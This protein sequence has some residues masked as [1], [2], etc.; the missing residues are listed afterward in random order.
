M[1]SMNDV[2]RRAGVSIA[3]VS[4]VLNNSSSVNEETRLKILKAIKELKY[5]PSRVAKRLRSKGG[6]GNLLGVLIPDIQNPFYVD[7]LRGIEDI[8]YKNNYV[9]I[10]CNFSQDEKKEAMY[11]DILES[12]AIDGLIA[13]PASE[14]DV[15][16]KKMVQNGLPVVCVDR[17]LNGIDV[18]VVWVN[19]DAGAF[20]AVDYLAKAGYKRIGHIAGLPTIPSSRL[21]EA[22]YRRALAE[23]NLPFDPQWLVYGNSTYK[24]GVELAEK[25]LSL[26]TPP[27][28]LFTGNNL[29]T[30]GALETIHKRKLHIPNDV[31]IIGFDDMN[32]SNSLNPPLTAVRQP[33][34]EIGQRAGE[35]LIQRIRDPKRAPIQMT[36][37]SE[38]MVRG[39]C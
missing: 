14:D 39:S 15:R 32:W 21:R 1:A 13:A 8:A 3:T 5:Q 19:N 16:V 29:I 35:L 25:L 27:D 18:D 9:I 12:E 26:P 2:A 22:G 4:R 11:L 28:A 33:A 34:Y 24:S 23:N 17:G 37:N 10:V 30:L 7:V 31:A 38:L 20:A 36:L 6:P